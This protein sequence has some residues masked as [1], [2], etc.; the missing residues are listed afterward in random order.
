VTDL[1]LFAVHVLIS[2]LPVVFF[3]SGLVLIDSYKLVRPKAVGLALLAGGVAAGMAYVVNSSLLDATGLSSLHYSRY[4]APFTEE[5]L[6]AMWILYL[7]R[8]D[9]I[10]FSV[11][12]AISGFAIGAGFSVIEN[13]YFL[14][15]MDAGTQTWI[16]R[17]FGTAIMHGVTTTV[18]AIVYKTLQH[19]EKRYS[20]LALSGALLAAYLLHS[21]YNHF[22]FP[23]LISTGFLLITSPLLVSF[24]FSH[25]EK[26]TRSWLGTGFDTDQE[27]LTLLMAGD[28][29]DS[30]VG[31]YLTSLKDHFEGTIVADM[32][33]LIR[34]RVELSI[35]AKGVLMMRE[36]GFE[37]KPDDMVK[38]KFAELTYLE[39]TIGR[40]GLLA[41][42]P[43]H[44]WSS[45]DLWQLNMLAEQ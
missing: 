44:K 26:L 31:S 1:G 6:K 17:G 22:P 8:S 19:D 13:I 14:S 38:S 30:R 29:S 41:I 27:L 28:F 10:G 5:S 40:T 43:I 25:S 3:L 20:A 39:K 4:L 36:A 15:A 34:L 11:D 12:A 7:V 18:F 33:C 45:Q 9:K 16:V 42:D 35:R 21:V 32:F 37:P 24:V 23:P 2:V